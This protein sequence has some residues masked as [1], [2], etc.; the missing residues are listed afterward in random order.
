M[1]KDLIAIIGV[2]ISLAGLI[3]Y[4]HHNLRTEILYLREETR[5]GFRMVREE[6][7]AMRSEIRCLRD[8][9]TGSSELVAGP[10]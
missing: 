7:E 6:F 2:G 1:S 4:S 3:L 8:A 9:I 5:A 10:G